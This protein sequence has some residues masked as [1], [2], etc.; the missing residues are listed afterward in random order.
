MNIEQSITA[1]GFANIGNIVANT[2]FLEKALRHALLK[3]QSIF[4]IASVQN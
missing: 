1:V 4:I 3:G 2:L